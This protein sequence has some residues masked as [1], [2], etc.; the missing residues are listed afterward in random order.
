M[1]ASPRNR[2]YGSAKIDERTFL[3][4]A[5]CFARDLSISDS[6]KS[7]NLSERAVA[8]IFSRL[9]KRIYEHALADPDAFNRAGH[10]VAMM[11]DKVI[12]HKRQ[13]DDESVS[14]Y[15]SMIFTGRYVSYETFF[16]FYPSLHFKLAN[17]RPYIWKYFSAWM[18]CKGTRRAYMVLHF[19][20]W[21]CRV[22][23]LYVR[24]RSVMSEPS[25]IEWRILE[26]R[27]GKG[28]QDIEKLLKCAGHDKNEKIGF[29]KSGYQHFY[30][31]ILRMISNQPL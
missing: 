3:R 2:F 21:C 6:A 23:C 20:E 29:P 12:R 26:S 16:H 10:V 22:Q 19:V 31:E 30:H 13:N 5:S 4:L 1:A 9:R 24:R 27:T 25:P 11:I 17:S 8:Q 15:P 7:T 28:F 14:T 18:K